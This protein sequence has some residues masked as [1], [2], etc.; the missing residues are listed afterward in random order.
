MMRLLLLSLFFF[1]LHTVSAAPLSPNETDHRSCGNEVSEEDARSIEEQFRIDL[2]SAG[3][4]ETDFDLERAAPITVV[5]HVVYAAATSSGGYL[6]NAAIS[7]SISAMNAHYAGSGF[8]FTLSRVTRTRNSNW[9]YYADQDTAAEA[10]MKRSLRVGGRNVLNVYSV[11]VGGG[12]LGYSAFPWRYSNAPYNDGVVMLYSSVPGGTK[13][14]YN[15]GKTLTH[16]VGHW[17][18]LYHVFQGNSCS[19]SGDYVSDTPPQ[20]T[21]TGGCPSYKDTCTGGGPDSIHNYMDYSYDQC[22]YQFT[23]GQYGRARVM[24]SFYRGIS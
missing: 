17:L 11:G 3:R 16:E 22:M 21:S 23:S 1:L 14:N 4:N 18:G 5:W 6:S 13:T 20:L 2:G 8:T 10:S 12:F 7:S 15:Q 9:F 24:A 19:G